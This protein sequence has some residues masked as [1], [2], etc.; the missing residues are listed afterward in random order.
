MLLR[1]I[2]KDGKFHIDRGLWLHDETN[3]IIACIAVR[4]ELVKFVKLCIALNQPVPKDVFEVLL[5]TDFKNPNG[6]F[7]NLRRKLIN[8][9]S[10]LGFN[11]LYFDTLPVYPEIRSS[12]ETI[13]EYDQW[14]E[15]LSKRVI[16]KLR[17]S[18]TYDFSRV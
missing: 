10:S 1:R 14:R 12:F 18:T 11:I 9:V 8:R 7:K 13:E 17:E 4:K 15:D 16:M 6:R 5:L 3:E 2:G